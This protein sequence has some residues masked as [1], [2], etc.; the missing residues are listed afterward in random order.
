MNKVTHTYAVL[1]ISETAYN[2]IKT[3]LQEAGYNFAFHGD[4]IDMHGIAVK[5]KE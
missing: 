1:E 3:K 2:E 4:L 5:A